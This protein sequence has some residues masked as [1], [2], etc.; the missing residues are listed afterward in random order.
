MVA[1]IIAICIV[2]FAA[3]AFGAWLHNRGGRR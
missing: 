3:G 2:C 1:R